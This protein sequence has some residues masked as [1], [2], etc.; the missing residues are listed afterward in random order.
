MDT[1]T[2]PFIAVSEPS[3]VKNAP[4]RKR[5]VAVWSL[6]FFSLALSAA[7]V[8]LA[9]S[10]ARLR[11]SCDES[12][13]SNN[14]SNNNNNNN[15]V[16]AA[17][18]IPTQFTASGVQVTSLSGQTST[19]DWHYDATSTRETMVYRLNSGA[20]LH[21]RKDY[22]AGIVEMHDPA[23]MTGSCI[24][25]PMTRT[26]MHK[27][28]AVS[29]KPAGSQTDKN[30]NT[31][32]RYAATRADASTFYFAVNSNE[33]LCAIEVD[34]TVYRF[35]PS[36]IV[37]GVTDVMLNPMCV[38]EHVVLSADASVQTNSFFSHIWGSAKCYACEKA[39]GWVIGK[40]A[41]GAGDAVCSETGP[42]AAACGFI[43]EEAVDG[44]CEH[45]NCD[46]RA[47]HA[48]HLC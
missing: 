21:F 27:F 31:C 1:A 22:A 16:L 11:S 8:A 3:A 38:E 46:E 13:N 45:Y 28:A 33:Q 7:V 24:G 17:S 48:I 37:T 5:S 35:D 25:Y 39:I 41:D 30:G 40:I 2:E 23:N 36:K 43:F 14:N 19:M 12:C 47:C 10:Y 4:A 9:V 42:F 32:S 44:I 34:G 20:E 29:I 15:N 18:A 6:T 26:T